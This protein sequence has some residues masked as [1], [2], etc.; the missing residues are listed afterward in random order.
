MRSG[1][2]KTIVGVP[3]DTA[4]AAPRTLPSAPRSAW[5]AVAWFGLVIAIIGFGQMLI[6]LYPAMGFGSPEWEFATPAQMIGSLP[7]PTMGV[8][9]MLAAAL[10]LGSRRG[11]TA[12]AVLL[13]ALTLFAVFALLLFWLVV[14]V[15]LRNAPEIAG[16]NIRQTV[17]R[18]TLSGLGFAVLYAGSAIAAVRHLRKA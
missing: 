9:A 5:K 6:Y 2:G 1:T 16:T 18:T 14:P 4:P 12:L 15:A 7:F 8:A 11:L 17:L 10:A 13:L 3:E